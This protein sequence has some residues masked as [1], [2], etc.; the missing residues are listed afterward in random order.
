MP[1]GSGTQY[2]GNMQNSY[3][4]MPN[5]FQLGLIQSHSQDYMQNNKFGQDVNGMA[6]Q[7]PMTDTKNKENNDLL[8]D[9]QLTETDVQRTHS[10]DD[11]TN[12]SYI[13]KDNE[14]N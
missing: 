5:G 13:Y 7:I 1:I 3:Q 8:N 6:S 11:R 9:T 10:R 12:L 14:D 4:K 2:V